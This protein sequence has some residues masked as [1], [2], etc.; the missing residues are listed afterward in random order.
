MQG[1]PD[2]VAG[3][4]TRKDLGEVTVEALL[5]EATKDASFEVCNARKNFMGME[6]CCRLVERESEGR[7]GQEGGAEL[8][9]RVSETERISEAAGQGL[10]SYAAMDV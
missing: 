7:G 4:I 8:S 10:Q 1:D 3:L 5:S 6:V 2:G 9:V